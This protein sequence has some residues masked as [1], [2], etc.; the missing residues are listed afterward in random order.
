L[1]DGNSISGGAVNY[2]EVYTSN[3]LSAY[4][5][6]RNNNGTAGN[7]LNCRI[8][9]FNIVQD[10]I[11]VL[12]LIPC[13]RNS[14][15]VL[16]MYDTVTGTFLTNAGTG[17]FIA[18]ADVELEGL[19][20]NFTNE[21]G[22][23]TSSALAPYALSAD[24]STVATS[25]SYNDLTN[26]PTIPDTSNLANKDLS[27]LSSTGDAKFQEPLVSGTNIKTINNNSILGSGNITI[28]SAPDIDNKS[29][30]TNT[31]DELQ[32]VG[33]I[34]SNNTTNAIKTWTGTKA[35]Y[36]AIIT[37]D[38]TTLYN[39]TDDTDVTI[40][41]LEIL[42]PVGS[43]YIATA[44]ISVCPLAVL[45]VGN[46]QQKANS[47]LVTDIISSAPVVGNG[48][49]LGLTNGTGY[50]GL[51]G[52]YSSASGNGNLKAG[53]FLYGAPVNSTEATGSPELNGNIG[54]TTDPTKSGIEAN[55]T[56]T[57]LSVTIWE[58]IS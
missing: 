44:S 6:A 2:P 56:S 50:A 45:G 16:G 20:I 49:S 5:F 35:Q 24:L 11:V 25:G 42:Y 7:F 1:L 34:D 51:G 57:T 32:T 38:T 36:E 39:I 10:G 47:T 37:K 17:D 21:S 33:V 18:G 8:Y 9:S 41:L 14:D 19:V 31:S 4:L 22:Y 13:R 3:T 28:Q 52:M 46:W 29:I 23:I 58:R 15:N 30:T 40:P 55:I 12:N 27:N 48:L 53:G 54:V 26:K 43:L